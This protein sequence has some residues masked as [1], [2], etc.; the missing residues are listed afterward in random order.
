MVC[1]EQCGCNQTVAPALPKALPRF[2]VHFGIVEAGDDLQAFKAEEVDPAFSLVLSRSLPVGRRRNRGR[3][4]DRMPYMGQPSV[5]R[6]ASASVIAAA[7]A[8]LSDLRP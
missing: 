4:T 2:K 6:S 5:W 7:T 1:Q 3:L 8:T